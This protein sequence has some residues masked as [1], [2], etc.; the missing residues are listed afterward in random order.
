LIFD[1]ESEEV[2]CGPC[3]DFLRRHS[4][5]PPAALEIDGDDDFVW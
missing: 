2:Y 3:L 4:A 1:E 5:S